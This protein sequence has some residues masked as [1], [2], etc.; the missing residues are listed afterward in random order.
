MS[1]W[2]GSAEDL[3]KAVFDVTGKQIEDS[4]TV[5]GKTIK[6]F[7]RKLYYDDIEHTETRSS[8]KRAHVFKKRVKDTYCAYHRSFYDRD[9]EEY[10]HIQTQVS[11]VS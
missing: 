11:H 2:K 1:G 5:V 3:T 10:C 6:K 9:D 8:S 4:A 7:E